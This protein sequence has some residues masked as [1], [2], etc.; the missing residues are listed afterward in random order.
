MAR[1]ENNMAND[2]CPGIQAIVHWAEEGQWLRFRNPMEIFL[3]ADPKEVVSILA[4]VEKE[5]E[6]KKAYAAGFLAYEAGA[7]FDP[8]LRFRP[9]GDFPLLW[10]GLFKEAEQ[11]AVP[12]VGGPPVWSPSFAKKPHPDAED[13][14]AFLASEGSAKMLCG[15]PRGA[16]PE[17]QSSVTREEYRTAVRAIKSFILQGATYQVNYSYRLRAP[18]DA[19]ALPYFLQIAGRQNIPYAAFVECGH[20]AVC[21][22]S[23]ELFFSLRDGVI[24]SKPMKGTM[25]RGR[26]LG[27]DLENSRRLYL[28][29]KNRAEN[30]MIVDMVRNDLGRIAAKNTVAVS[31]LYD[32]EKY[33][34]VWQMTSTVKARTSAALVD[35]FRALF[36]PAS[37]TGAPKVRTT[38]II[39][40]LETSPR[41]IYTGAVGFLAPGRLAQFNVAIRTLLVDKRCGAAEFGVGGGIVWDST[42]EAE[43]DECAVKSKIVCT[44][45]VDFELL[46]T[47]LWTPE[48]TPCPSATDEPDIGAGYFLLDLHMDRMRASAAYFSFPFNENK[49]RAKLVALASE[50]SVHPALSKAEGPRRVRL[51]LSRAGKISLETA[52]Y[53]PDNAQAT[54][55]VY[56]ALRRDL[57]SIGMA[58]GM[59]KICLAKHPVASDNVFLYHKTTNRL[60]YDQA[61]ALCPGHDEVILWN[62]KGEV[63][64]FCAGNIIVDLEG[65]MLTPPVNCGLLPGTYRH[66]LL[67]KGAIREQI[68]KTDML[69]QCRRILFCNSVRKMQE[70]HLS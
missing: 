67:K 1:K 47:M 59:M 43:Y 48:K 64:E 37:C 68:I 22:F 45:A 56:H 21:S 36:P 41:R 26:L 24:V 25:P 61:K 52:P 20:Y 16:S 34:T 60:V 3:T 30:V 31:S 62:E 2:A 8:A 17:W 50:F 70:V 10:F 14:M 19:V 5:V 13:G 42:D 40:E 69:R 9:V 29:E 46:E 35:I 23:P 58:K 28:S 51:L 6:T 38:R 55:Q 33:D 49:T 54:C 15:L 65:Q 63:T 32:I 7:A 44:P 39:A 57:P 66:W 27:D 53:Q 12:S 11:F 4:H 18:F